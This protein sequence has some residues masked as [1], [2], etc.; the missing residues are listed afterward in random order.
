LNIIAHLLADFFFQSDKWCKSKES[1]GF[2]SSKL[3]LHALVVFLL[4]ALLSFSP[5]FIPYAFVIAVLHLLTD[6]VKSVLSSRKK[7]N[8]YLFFIDQ[9]IHLTVLSGVVYLYARGQEVRFPFEIQTNLLYYLVG[10]LLCAKPTNILIKK[11][12]ELYE[13]KIEN[14]ASLLNAGKLIG[15][16]ER[17]LTLTFVLLGRFEAVG[18]LIAAKSILRYKEGD[19]KRTEYVLIGTLLSFG[20]AVLTGIGIECAL[21]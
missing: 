12:F 2:F 18:F 4:A 20:V 13:I 19:V 21:K 17:I 16:Y 8:G 11:I 10:Y 3:Y 5:D 15:V 6:G 9:G 1:K 14:Q 7:I